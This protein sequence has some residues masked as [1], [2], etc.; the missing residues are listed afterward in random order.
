MVDVARHFFTVEQV[1]RYVDQLAQYKV[2]TL[3][4]HLTDDQGWRLAID[5]WPRL[6]EYG[7]GSEVGGG[8]GGHWTKAEYR[9]LVAYA[10]SGTSSWCRRST[11]RAT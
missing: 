1:K 4:V 2:N 10:G 9:D 8:P 7:G 6:A 3:H 11:C 5:S